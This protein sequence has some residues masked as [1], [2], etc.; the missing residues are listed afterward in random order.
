MCISIR[1]DTQ[2]YLYFLE[3][4]ED[5]GIELNEDEHVH[6]ITDTTSNI[7]NMYIKDELFMVLPQIVIIAWVRYFGCF[8]DLKKAAD[9][10][11]SWITK[12]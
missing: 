9:K 12:T 5:K 6:M 2:F 1:N 3:N 7:L 4:D 10:A 8:E 11:D